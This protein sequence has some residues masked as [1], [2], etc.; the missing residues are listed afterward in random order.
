MLLCCSGLEH[1]RVPTCC[2]CCR[3][4]G[5]QALQ[6]LDGRLEHLLLLQL[7]M[8]QLPFTRTTAKDGKTTTHQKWRGWIDVSRQS[9]VLMHYI[10]HPTLTHADNLRQHCL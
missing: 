8:L 6:L 10:C 7:F 5:S 3:C 1:V 2:C 9:L 4:G